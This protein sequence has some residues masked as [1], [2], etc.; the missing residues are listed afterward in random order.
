MAH[1]VIECRS[2][3][4]VAE[5]DL[6]LAHTWLTQ[7]LLAF[8]SGI[9]LVYKGQ[10]RAEIV[11]LKERIE[12]QIMDGNIAGPRNGATWTMLAKFTTHRAL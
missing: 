6:V 5:D 7:D 12:A 8:H 10:H 9:G 11:A 1:A 2:P 3:E 4:Q